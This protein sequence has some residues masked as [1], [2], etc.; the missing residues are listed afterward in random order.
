MCI[1]DRKSTLYQLADNT[2]NI[3]GAYAR[4]ILIETDGYE[5]TEPIILPE[6]GLK[7]GSFVF[8]LPDAKTFKPEYVKLYPNPARDYIIVELMTG[9]VNGATVQMFDMQGKPV[10]NAEIPGQ[11]QH[12]V[13]PIKE[14]QTGI[15]Y[16]KVEMNGK[17]LENK[18]FSKIK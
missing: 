2:R 6:E 1:R 13:L 14:L 16:L 4:N 7:S 5:Y 17:T 9:N 3:A 11:K 18:K 12:Y 8:D 10:K 15:Y